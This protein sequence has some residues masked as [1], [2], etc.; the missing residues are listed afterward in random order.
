MP[1]IVRDGRPAGGQLGDLD[2]R[3]VRRHHRLPARGRVRGL[4]GRGAAAGLL[5]RRGRRTSRRRVL[6]G[7][8]AVPA[9]RAGCRQPVARRRCAGV[10]EPTSARARMAG[11]PA[12]RDRAAGEHAPGRRRPVHDSASLLAITAALRRR[13]LA[14]RGRRTRRSSPTASSRPAIG[15]G[16]LIGGFVVGLSARALAKGRMVIVGYAICGALRSIGARV[17]RQSCRSRSACMLGGGIA[18]MVYVIPS[19]TL[20]QERTP[21][22]MI[23]RVVG[24]RF[25]LVFGVADAG[26]GRRRASA[27]EVDRHRARA[28]SSAGS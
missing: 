20:F 22:D 17:R 16:N 7:S 6:I 12:Q 14:R 4:P 27:V 2:R 5:A 1:R 26:D 11:I 15:I 13:V 3:D 19:Q 9:A 28:R 8:M 18:N 24:F 21:A 25:A 10:L 23:G